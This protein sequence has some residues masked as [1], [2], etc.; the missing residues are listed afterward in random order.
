MPPRLPHPPTW[1][2][3]LCVPAWLAGAPAWGAGEQDQFQVG[4]QPDGRIV[5][6]TNQVLKPAGKQI[7]FPG[8]P[9][10]LALT[11]EGKTLVVKNMRDLVFIDVATAKVK[12]VLDLPNAKQSNIADVM[13]HP[14]GPDGKPHP[15]YPVGFSVVGLVVQHDRVYASDSSNHIHVALRQKDGSYQ[16]SERIELIPPKVG[17]VA[18]ATGIAQLSSHE[19]WVASSRG[20]CVQW[21][22]LVTGRAEQVVAVGVA[23]YMICSPRPERLYV[24]NWGGDPPKQS[25]P[26]ALSSG[27]PVRIDAKTGI[28]NRGTVSV[29]AP[30]PGHWKQV[31]TIRVGL[32]PSGII[33]GR[34]GKLLYVA[35]AN[36]DSVSVIDTR[37]D[38][39][40]ETISCRP[41]ARLPFGSGA[42]AVALSPDGG[43]LYVANG[44]NNCIAVIRLGARARE[45]ADA[46]GPARSVVRGLIPTGWFP[47]AL[48]LSADGKTLFVA[49][50]KGVGS[51]SQPRPVAEGK[52]THDF[53]GSVSIIEVPD[54]ARLAKYTDEVNANNRLGYSLAGL[55][56]PRAD[57]QPVPVP[58]RHGEPSVFKHV[59]YVIKENRSYDQIFGDI[60][61]GNGDPKL[62][63]FGE[64]VTPNQHALA[65]QF[66]L[67]DNFYCS[68]ALSATGHQWVSEAYCTD[69][70]EKA[71]GGFTRSYP[72]DGDDT[73][74]F[75]S[76]GFLWDNALTHQKTFRDYGEF[77]KTT[78]D[79]RTATWTDVYNDYKNGTRNVKLEVKANVQAM[80][81]H[82]RPGYPGF[83]LTTPDVYR[84]QLLLEDLK[85]Y[86]RKGEFPN[87]VYVFLPCDHTTGTRPGY[88]T[89]RAMIADNDLA[90]GRIVEAVT[91]SKFWPETCIFV[92]EDDPQ[93]GFDH[94]DGHRSFIQ[95]ISPY[96]KRRFVDHS[97]YN[98]TSIVKTIELILGLPPMNQLDLSASP[99]R[100]CFQDKPDLTPFRSVPNKV[101]LDEMNPP[102]SRLRGKA[103]YWAQKSL[104]LDFDEADEADEDTLNRILW[105]ASRGYDT[106]Y[107]ERD[108]EAPH[109]QD[110]GGR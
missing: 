66:T 18:D 33:A 46:D 14:L 67:F 92:V 97:N 19:L 88:P 75:A 35:N 99:L 94:V 7:T 52:N 106:P 4:L 98:H 82:V 74:A 100:R 3:A 26:Q 101:A 102:L 22:N 83:P 54:A 31:K 17:G 1:I 40:V 89:P 91:R 81:P 30:A 79:P 105:H 84:A 95:V 41:E 38:D 65:R 39:V 53:L 60:K 13:K 58:R 56:K 103:L 47:G 27:S 15:P 55:S 80:A 2:V 48:R 93:F 10:D 110:R 50:V 42:N 108:G 71:F 73:L 62:L 86:E 49:N 59:I 69:Y 23:P 34:Q 78:Y 77:T 36:S 107:P 72:V 6:P 96:T 16:W 43:T 11:D 29:V 24:T 85:A 28:P 51:L 76:S 70:L 87:L 64:E 5:V 63:M 45:E 20:N 109:T 37:S 9:V 104:E 8:R 12:Q 21:I 25:E 61:E 68:S 57:A 32:H 44:S 90:L